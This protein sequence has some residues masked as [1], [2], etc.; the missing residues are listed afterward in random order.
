MRERVVD[1]SAQALQEDHSH[2]LHTGEDYLSSNYS[3]S[4]EE[5]PPNQEDRV[6][7]LVPRRQRSWAQKFHDAF[8]GVRLGV[9]GQNSFIVH[10]C[11]SVAVIIAGAVFRLSLTEWLIAG[12]CIVIVWTAEMFNSA[13]ERLARAVNHKYDPNIRDALDIGSGAVLVAA[14][15]AATLGSILFLTH[16]LRWVANQL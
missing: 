3:P 10:G 5:P 16:F 7:T 11:F 2:P 12:L 8:R 1:Y 14:I 9:W 4:A 13:L 15:G 6:K